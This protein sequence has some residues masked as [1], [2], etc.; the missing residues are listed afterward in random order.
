MRQRKQLE[1]AAGRLT[2]P[3]QETK[4]RFERAVPLLFQII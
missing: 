1:A 2:C 3:Q 4:L